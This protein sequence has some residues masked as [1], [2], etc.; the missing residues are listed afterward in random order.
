MRVSIQVRQ[1]GALLSEYFAPWTDFARDRLSTI[2]SVWEVPYFDIDCHAEDGGLAGLTV[3]VKEAS[4]TGRIIYEA[5]VMEFGA[6][7]YWAMH[8]ADDVVPGVNME[9]LL[10]LNGSVGVLFSTQGEYLCSE[11]DDLELTQAIQD[12]ADKFSP[13]R[14]KRRRRVR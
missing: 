11:W 5:G 2:S 13:A 14:S 9:V 12:I 7:P 4:R 1:R 10:F 8:E 3:H 6:G